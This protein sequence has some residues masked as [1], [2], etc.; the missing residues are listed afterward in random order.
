MSYDVIKH[1]TINHPAFTSVNASLTSEIQRLY[2]IFREP[3]PNGFQSA[4][5]VENLNTGEIEYSKGIPGKSGTFA[6]VK[7]ETLRKF[8]HLAL[9][10]ACTIPELIE[11]IYSQRPNYDV[12]TFSSLENVCQLTRAQH[13][14]L[15]REIGI[16]AY[17]GGIRIPFTRITSLLRSNEEE[18]PAKSASASAL[19][20]AKEIS[21]CVSFCSM[22]CRR[23]CKSR[24]GYHLPFR[25]L[26]NQAEQH[27]SLSSE[28]ARRP[29]N[30]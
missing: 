1:T 10:G 6:A 14:E 5:E 2:Q 4:I 29:G 20:V 18:T 30:S 24:T 15:R 28:D 21:V 16:T 25:L 26:C 22:S 9:T 27:R 3:M 12:S 19:S 17:L 13:A 7:M 23:P 8:R 11:M